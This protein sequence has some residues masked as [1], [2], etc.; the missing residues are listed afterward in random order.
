MSL[1]AQSFIAAARRYL[2]GYRLPLLDH[3]GNCAANASNT[4]AFCHPVVGLNNAC[5]ANDQV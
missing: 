1:A 4:E 2:K 5:A 3:G